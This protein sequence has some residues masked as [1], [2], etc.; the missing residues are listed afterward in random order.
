MGNSGNAQLYRLL[1]L[2]TLFSVAMGML[3]SSV[4]VYLRELYYPDGF[5]F[6]IRA[7]S[8]TVAIT[9]LMRELATLIMLLTIGMVAGKTKQERFAWF[10]YSFAIW[11]IFYYLFL[12]LIISWPNSLT[13]WDIL[14]LLPMM[15][16]GP[17]WA[18]LLLSILMMILAICILVFSNLHKNAHLKL[19]E[20][21]LL[22][23]GSIVVIIAFCK[24]FYISMT[25]LYPL[26]P[27]TILFFS[28]QTGEYAEKYVPKSF[29]VTLFTIG[30]ILIFAGICIYVLRNRKEIKMNIMSLGASTMKS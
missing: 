3:E 20:W 17:V 28:K 8:Y 1:V 21:V 18:P 5:Q 22:V 26:I 11:D 9:E 12:Y 15:W 23:S 2:I 30:S 24:D 27:E 14:F 19:K 29:D 4:V 25:T 10:I 13:D 16:T 7:T 6:P